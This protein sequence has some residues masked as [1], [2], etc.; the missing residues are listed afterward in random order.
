[1]D[2]KILKVRRNVKE[3]QSAIN[4]L[5][6]LYNQ[7]EKKPGEEEENLIMS[8]E[9]ALR[10]SL[11]DINKKLINNLKQV[12]LAK[13][14]KQELQENIP[15]IKNQLA[16]PIQKQEPK[17]KIIEP[18][19]TEKVKSK[20]TKELKP[21]G[22][23]KNTIKRLKTQGKKEYKQKIRKPNKYSIFAT[24]L[25]RKR[26]I[27]SLEKGH[28][29]H[30]ERDLAKANLQFTPTNYIS[31]LFLTVLISF[32]IGAFIY[33]F[34]VFFNFGANLPIITRATG[35]LGQRALRISWILI[36][37]PLIAFFIA[38][39][40]P[41]LEKKSVEHNINQELPFASINMAAISGSLID[42]S[43]IFQIIIKTGEY[44][45]IS[46]EFTKV[47]NEINIYGYN[48]VTALRDAASNSASKKL[49]ELFTGLATT[50]GSG[51]DLPNFFDQRAKGL[52]FEHKLQKE[53]EAKGA[54]TFMDI[55]ISVVIAA[56]MIL[57]L[58]LVMMKISG[59]GL[60]MSTSTITV[61][62]V[63]AVTVMNII[64]LG[65]LQA[66]KT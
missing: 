30:L 10:K 19:P 15:K 2:N 52:L 50:I 32:F 66:K 25:F 28:F 14:L 31:I 42:P 11:S 13:P 22:L 36:V 63:L 53:R 16:R 7:I 49:R 39:L 59:L 38:Y 61:I 40:Y 5:N 64:F 56:P 3:I 62:M 12:Y 33:L 43:K 29:P 26:A 20:L 17:E 41:S 55:Y 34:F 48:L 58:V 45:N 6:S 60:A 8:Q 23:E 35:N 51:G 65:F 1:M 24:K 27:I 46:K 18:P 4:E 37:V 21:K 47:M 9:E 54:E 57:M 44:P